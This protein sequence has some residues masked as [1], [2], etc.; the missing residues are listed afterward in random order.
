MRTVLNSYIFIINRWTSSSYK[1]TAFLPLSKT[2]D[3]VVTKA[4]EKDE[5]PMTKSIWSTKDL[6][7][8]IADM[9]YEQN[10][11]HP[12]TYRHLKIGAPLNHSAD[13]TGRLSANVDI[14][15]NPFALPDSKNRMEEIRD[16]Y[17]F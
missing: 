15:S 16:K 13:Y 2:A 12:P 8:Q 14:G 1:G 17:T 4:G 10:L 5:L 11:W 9:E 7:K 3:K 6:S